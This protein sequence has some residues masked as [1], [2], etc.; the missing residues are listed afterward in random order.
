MGSLIIPAFQER[1]RTKPC[2]PPESHH[3]T[4]PFNHFESTPQAITND[5]TFLTLQYALPTIR[6]LIS[7]ASIFPPVSTG[8]GLRH[9]M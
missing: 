2:E 1:V 4:Y 7:Y 5:K 3:W 8:D 6:Y 9:V